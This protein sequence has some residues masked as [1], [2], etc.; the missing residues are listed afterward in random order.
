[1]RSKA[2]AMAVPHAKQDKLCLIKCFLD[3]GWVAIPSR[4]GHAKVFLRLFL[5]AYF[6]L[7]LQGSAFSQVEC[8]I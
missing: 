4:L 2:E 7:N 8:K 3:N 5:R 1:M 6:C